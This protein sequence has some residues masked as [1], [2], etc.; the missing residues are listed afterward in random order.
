MYAYIQ[1]KYFVLSIQNVQGSWLYNRF[2]SNNHFPLKC[3]LQNGSIIVNI[4]CYVFEAFFKIVI[5]VY[6]PPMVPFLLVGPLVRRRRRFVI[7]S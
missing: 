7:I 6:V 2:L 3:L 5:E 4:G 1:T